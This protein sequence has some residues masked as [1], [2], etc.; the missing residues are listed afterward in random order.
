VPSEDADEHAISLVIEVKGAWHKD[1]CDALRP[2][3]VD[4]Y[5]HDIATQY[6]IYLVAWP[7]LDSCRTST[8]NDAQPSGGPATRPTPIS[9]DTHAN[10]GPT[11]CTWPSLS[12]SHKVG[13]RPT[14]PMTRAC[15][16]TRGSR[17][18]AAAKPVTSVAEFRTGHVVRVWIGRGI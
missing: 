8:P 5:M 17:M 4:R 6:G 10:S 12:T 9:N 16:A 15:G 11:A 7:D 13:D 2:Q 3:L 1:L 14:R 18:A